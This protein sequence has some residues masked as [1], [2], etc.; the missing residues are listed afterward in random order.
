MCELEEAG[1]RAS[2]ICLYLLPPNLVAFLLR[3]V[4]PH[5]TSLHPPSPPQSPSLGPIPTKS[6]FGVLVKALVITLPHHCHP[7][8]IHSCT[9]SHTHSHTHTLTDTHTHTL[10]LIQTH[11]HNLP[12]LLVLL[13]DYSLFKEPQN[14]KE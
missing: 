7:P 6:F 12:L 1:R 10:T 13:T 4:P 5:F 11:T 14:C 8:A 2:R 3:R 9:H